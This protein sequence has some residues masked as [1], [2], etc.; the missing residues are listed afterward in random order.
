[1]SNYIYLDL[2]SV[3]LD[4]LNELCRPI[5]EEEN[6]TLKAPYQVGTSQYTDGVINPTDPDRKLCVINGKM[7]AFAQ[8]TPAVAAIIEEYKITKEQA[9]ARGWFL[10]YNIN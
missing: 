8:I 5:W 2:P 10:P 3:I 9:I 6:G 4:N 7:S 1:M